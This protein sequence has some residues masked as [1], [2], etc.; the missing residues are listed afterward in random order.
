MWLAPALGR[1]WSAAGGSLL[2]LGT[3]LFF[4]GVTVWEH[5]LTVALSLGAWLLLAH[6]S[7]SRAF[8]AG[9]CIGIAC[10]FREE[11]VLMGIATGIAILCRFGRYTS[12]PLALTRCLFRVMAPS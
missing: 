6:P 5:S 10:W 9:L 1:R 11:L 8:A 7:A 4:Y 2:A 3:P 12:S